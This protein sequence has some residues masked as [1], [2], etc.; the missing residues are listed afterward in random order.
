MARYALDIEATGLL[1]HTSIDY[2]VV[3]Y[4]LKKSYKIWCAVFVDIDTR[5]RIRL[6]PD[7]VD[8]IPKIIEDRADMLVLHNGISYDLLA[9]KLYF[10]LDYEI[11]EYD[12]T[13]CKVGGKE[14]AIVDTM[15]LSQYLKPDRIGGHS[16]HAWGKRLGNLKGDYGEEENAWDQ[17]TEDMLDYNEQDSDVTA[18]VFFALI[19]G[20]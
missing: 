4:K 16:L 9:L 14:V 19:E 13:K 10:G 7:E 17:F 20:S 12:Y 18:D 15:I 3:P 6:R 5:E 1:D 11:N 2:S 8:Q